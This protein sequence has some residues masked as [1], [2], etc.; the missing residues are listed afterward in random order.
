LSKEVNNADPK[1]KKRAVQA[2]LEEIRIFP[3]D[4][5]P[6]QRL[7]K[8]KGDCLPLTPVKVASLREFHPYYETIKLRITLEF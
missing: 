5:S 7:L 3:K 8:I 2:L 6:W 4:G 1:I